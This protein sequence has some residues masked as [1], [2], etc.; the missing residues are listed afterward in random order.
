[1]SLESPLGSRVTDG[2]LG[3][4]FFVVRVLGPTGGSH[5]RGLHPVTYGVGI[6]RAF[7][8]VRPA[9]QLVHR[10]KECR[11]QDAPEPARPCA[12]LQRLLRNR[13]QRVLGEG[14]V[15]LVVAEEL[16]VLPYQ[17]VLRLGEDA[18]EVLFGET[19]QSGDDRQPPDELGDQTVLEEVLGLDVLQDLV[20]LL[21][22][23]RVDVAPEAD[24]L[25]ADPLPDDLFQAPERPAADKENVLGVYLQKV[26][27]WVL[28]PT[29]W[30]HRR[31]RAF[32]DLQ[33][34]LLDDLARDVAGYGRVVALS[35]DLIDLV[36][37]NNSRLG[38]LDVEVSSLN[39]LQEDV[40]DVL[41]DVAGL[42]EGRGVRDGEGDVE[43]PGE[44]LGEQGLSRAGRSQKQ[45]VR[46]LKLGAVRGVGAHANALVVIIARDGEYLLRVL[47]AD[48]VLVE[49]AVDLARLGEVVVLK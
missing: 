13:L 34:G 30:R 44:R 47:L 9:R 20:G 8:N 3:R 12:P 17:G 27:V 35:R 41:A 28:A 49:D 22:Q 36:D 7:G 6:H 42:G 10:R 24:A 1:M 23:A 19:A 2:L 32:Q 43:D 21:A 4:L 37:V 26:L 25:F 16:P 5:E 15:D 33:Q 18:D 48:D 29:L 31:D 40:L 46:L 39:E 45:D 11:L 14:E 38:L